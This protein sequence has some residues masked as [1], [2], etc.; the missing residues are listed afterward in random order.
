MDRNSLGTLCGHITGDETAKVLRAT[1]DENDFAF[2]GMVCH[3][4]SP[5]R[6][7]GESRL[8]RFNAAINR[9]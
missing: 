1:R 4:E 5:S 2:N 6:I 3:G 8:G 9:G 7:D